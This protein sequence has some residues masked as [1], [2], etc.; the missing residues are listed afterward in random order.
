MFSYVS[1]YSPP[2]IVEGED[3]RVKRP[4]VVETTGG[5][6]RQG[7]KCVQQKAPDSSERIA[8]GTD[9]FDDFRVRLRGKR[10]TVNTVLNPF[11]DAKYRA[12]IIR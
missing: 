3:A 2:F 10:F 7:K 4:R 5:F 1:E 11:I 6:L 8:L 12:E 9:G